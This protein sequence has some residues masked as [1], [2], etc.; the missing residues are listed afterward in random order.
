MVVLLKTK[1]ERY[2]DTEAITNTLTRACT[3]KTNE[4]LVESWIN[5]LSQDNTKSHNLS[6]VSFLSETNAVII[7]L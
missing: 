6:N 7:I 5:A 4:S 1:D 2:I 3:M